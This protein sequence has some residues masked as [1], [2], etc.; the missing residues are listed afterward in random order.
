[1]IIAHCGTIVKFSTGS[2]VIGRCA[3]LVGKELSTGVDAAGL[4]VVPLGGELNTG[5]VDVAGFCTQD[6]MNRLSAMKVAPTE[7]ASGTPLDNCRLSEREL[8]VSS[9]NKRS[10]FNKSWLF[11]FHSSASEELFFPSQ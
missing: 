10:C 8:L 4:S 7:G 9:C 6:M 2:E 11:G 1:M 5:I 3:V